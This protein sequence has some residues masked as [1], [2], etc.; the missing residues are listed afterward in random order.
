MA[1]L[2]Q[3]RFGEALAA[4]GPVALDRE[5]DADA[6]LVRAVLLTIAGDV[7]EAE[8]VCARL[9]VLDELNAEA[10]YLT[11]LCREHARDLPGA[12][13][14]DRYAAYLDPTFAMPRLHLG[15]MASRAGQREVARRELAR[16]R[17][18]LEAEDAARVLL[19]GGG[20]RRE[21]LVALCDAELRG[22][23]GEA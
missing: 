17:V 11:A 6:L 9:L 15:L 16:A 8:R 19:L 5:R 20:F 23:G 3:E 14:H 10:H 18:L 2:E 1:L 7:D 12:A 4:L 13:D 21:A 22:R